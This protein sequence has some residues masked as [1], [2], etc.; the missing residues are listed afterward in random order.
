MLLPLVSLYMYSGG[1]ASR[2]FG[3]WVEGADRQTGQ[4]S[5]FAYLQNT[6]FSVLQLFSCF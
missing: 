4:K 2:Q 6:R 1:W 3:G 5:E